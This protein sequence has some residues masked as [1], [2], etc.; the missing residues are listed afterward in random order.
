MAVINRKS[1]FISLLLTFVLFL[2]SCSMKP[3]DAQVKADVES[4]L[5]NGWP[6]M[7]KMTSF[8]KV[9]GKGDSQRYTI[10]YHYTAEILQDTKGY[11]S[12]GMG[13]HICALNNFKWI[14]TQLPV[15]N[16]GAFYSPASIKKGDSFEVTSSITYEKTEKGWRP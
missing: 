5:K 9:N 12:V 10:D 16:L 4:Q 8:N 2:S 6:G 7:C 15:L 13:F 14:K 11:S 3:S 1:I